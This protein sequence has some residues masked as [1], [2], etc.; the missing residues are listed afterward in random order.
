MKLGAQVEAGRT[1][2]E[3]LAG[4]RRAEALGYHSIWS[5]QLPYARD[6]LTVLAAVAQATSTIR[7]GTAVL[8][9][10][11]RHP[12]QM[13]Q[14]AATLDELSNHRLMLGIGISHKVVVESMWGLRIAQPVEQMREY[15]TILRDLVHT[16]QANFDG[17]HF[18]AHASY[19]APH[20]EGMPILLAALGDHMLELAGELA[21]GVALWMC[22]PGYIRDRVIPR[23]K[24]ARERAGK[25]MDGF[26]VMAAIPVCLAAD[27]K[28]ARD[29]FRTVV[30]RYASLPFYR[31]MLEASGF[32][33]DLGRGEIPDR[34]LDELGG[35][36]DRD[37][38]HSILDRYREAGCTLGSVGSLPK[39]SVGFEATLE[40]AIG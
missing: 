20:N 26:E 1:I 8:P 5:S 35:I 9:I 25:T 17:D 37:A 19:A 23:V 29:G 14:A 13:A 28:Q 38:I 2:D 7:L 40:A 24:A 3:A 21:D 4:A 22:S 31:R 30:E 27:E 10:Y 6:T 16:G 34:M 12:T 18:T 15:L 33:D 39:G 32:A 11:Q 36:G